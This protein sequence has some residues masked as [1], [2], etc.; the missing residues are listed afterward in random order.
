M[1]ERIIRYPPKINLAF[2]FSSFNNSAM[3][4]KTTSIKLS[5]VLHRAAKTAAISAGMTFQQW[6]ETAFQSYLKK[7][8]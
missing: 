4:M 1:G 2:F 8:K 7:S 6:V 3:K 5:E